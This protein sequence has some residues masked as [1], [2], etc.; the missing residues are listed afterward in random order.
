MTKK[1]RNNGRANKGRGNVKRVNC[2]QCGF[3]VPKVF[4]NE[5]LIS[6]IID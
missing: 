3:M 6:S 5:F 2:Y 4:I 1:R